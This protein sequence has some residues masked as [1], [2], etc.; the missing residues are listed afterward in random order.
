MITLPN[1]NGASW[2]MRGSDLTL[3]T[4]NGQYNLIKAADVRPAASFQESE[5]DARGHTEVTLTVLPNV[6]GTI[7]YVEGRYVLQCGFKGELSLEERRI[8]KARG[9]VRPIP[10]DGLVGWEWKRDRTVH[11][12]RITLSPPTVYDCIRLKAS[13]Y[14]FVGV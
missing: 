9:R 12:C 3:S 1:V 11:R 5:E 2:K 10:T 6:G 7:E 14:G 4:T 8:D 13:G